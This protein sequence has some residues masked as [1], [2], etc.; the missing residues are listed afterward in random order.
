MI[1]KHLTKLARPL[2]KINQRLFT[3]QAASVKELHK[4]HHKN[5]LMEPKFYER[6]FWSTSIEE[7]DYVR[8]PLYDYAQVNTLK[9]DEEVHQH[10]EDL[11]LKFG[12]LDELSE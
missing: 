6:D 11:G 5:I 9:S 7:I 12:M 1:A 10:L 4:V 3:A 2:A 8:S